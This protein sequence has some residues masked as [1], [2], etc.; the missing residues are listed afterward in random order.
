[1]AHRKDI[2]TRESEIRQWIKELRPKVYMCRQLNCRPSTLENYLNK[3][4]IQYEG[5]QGGKGKKFGDKRP[6]KE[7]LKKDSQVSS[8]WLKLRLYK[9]GLKEPKCE[10]C[11][12]D[13]WNNRDLS[14]HL[15]HENGDRFDNRLPNL[16]IYCPNCHSQTDNYA[17]KK[18]GRLAER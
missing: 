6:I 17:A 9:E 12:I 15:H 11:K 1:M 14:F 18:N 13:S 4:G 2:L 8:H 16:K 5:N 10:N 3:L 7:Y